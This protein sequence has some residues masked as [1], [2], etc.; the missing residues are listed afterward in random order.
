M[1][2]YVLVHGG[3]SGAH[4][5]RHVRAPVRAADHDVYTPR[6]STAWVTGGC[7]STPPGGA[8]AREVLGLT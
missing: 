3:W 4:A 5:F 2:V 8:S 6:H 1:T 7:S